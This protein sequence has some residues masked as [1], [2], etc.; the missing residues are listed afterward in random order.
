MPIIASTVFSPR[1]LTNPIKW[2]RRVWKPL[3]DALLGLLGDAGWVAAT[4]T[5]GWTNVGAPYA[6]A[7]YR[8]RDG[9]LY[10]RGA[11]SGGALG[12][13]FT[14]PAAYTPANRTMLLLPAQGG[15]ARVDVRETGP[16]QVVAYA[17]GGTNTHVSLNGAFVVMDA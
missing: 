11:I 8:I 4:L 15:C 16:V 10:L 5:G 17:D 12:T 13:A 9:V 14:L 3:S 6:P 1:E 7:S 2:Y